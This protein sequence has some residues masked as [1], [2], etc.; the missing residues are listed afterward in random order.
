MTC[1][2]FLW[3]LSM[4]H[5]THKNIFSLSSQISPNTIIYA[6]CSSIF[7]HPCSQFF[8]WKPGTQSTLYCSCQ[9]TFK[10]SIFNW[11]CIAYFVKHLYLWHVPNSVFNGLSSLSLQQMAICRC[12][13]S[14]LRVG[15]IYSSRHCGQL[16]EWCTVLK[17][18]LLY[19]LFYITV[20]NFF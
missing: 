2:C 1:L 11:I 12:H 15:W 16:N 5:P 3:N 10:F 14:I 8:S 9:A 17:I 20:I 4:W 7:S 6:I 18:S 13:I 19:I